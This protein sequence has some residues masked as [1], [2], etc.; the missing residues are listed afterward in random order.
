[1]KILTYRYT[2]IS[3]Y[4]SGL[5]SIYRRRTRTIEGIRIATRN[6]EGLLVRMRFKIKLCFL[7]F[8]LIP[9]VLLQSSVCVRPLKTLDVTNVIS[10]LISSD[11]LRMEGLVEECIQFIVTHVNEVV[12]LPIDMS[13]INAN[14]LRSLA[15][16]V[17][18]PS[19]F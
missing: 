12:K 3:R 1:L 6:S 5:C 17:E 15:E 11:F 14:L 7:S 2:A 19:L 9:Q 10:I 18:V 16:K 4:L 13:C 8:V